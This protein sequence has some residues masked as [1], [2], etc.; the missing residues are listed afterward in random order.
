MKHTD[1]ADFNDD[2]QLIKLNIDWHEFEVDFDTYFNGGQGLTDGEWERVWF[3]VNELC[4]DENQIQSLDDKYKVGLIP[5]P[6]EEE[7]AQAVR[8]I[9]DNYLIQ[10]VDAVVSNPLRWAD[11]NQEEQE[12]IIQY[13][14]YLL[15]IPQS[16]GFPDVE[17]LDFNNWKENNNDNRRTDESISDTI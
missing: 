14:L 6:T 11:M 17:V 15:D 1:I 9:R 13:R 8:V 10:Y 3:A 12:A 7:K 2:G 16:E 4:D 5:E